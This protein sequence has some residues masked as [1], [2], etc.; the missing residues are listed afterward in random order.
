MNSL[1]EVCP[2]EPGV[3]G[4]CQGPYHSCLIYRAWRSKEV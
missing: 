2:V 4:N 3:G 1:A